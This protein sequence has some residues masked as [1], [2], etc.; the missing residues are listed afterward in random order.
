L[1]RRQL[2]RSGSEIIFF[3]FSFDDNEDCDAGGYRG[4]Y[5]VAVEV[6]T[7]NS[8]NKEPNSE[9]VDA[10]LGC[11]INVESVEVDDENDV[12]TVKIDYEFGLAG[13][14]VDADLNVIFTATVEGPTVGTADYVDGVSFVITD[15]G[16][17]ETWTIQNVVA[18]ADEV[19]TVYLTLPDVYEVGGQRKSV[20]TDFIG[21]RQFKVKVRK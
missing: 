17:Q 11:F 21:T 14:T 20:L 3:L 8:V 6:H 13:V 19:G 5:A 1:E 9:L 15:E 10:L 2:F 16:T 4:T 12:A 18:P 7:Q